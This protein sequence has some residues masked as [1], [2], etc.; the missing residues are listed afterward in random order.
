[1]TEAAYSPE[2]QAM[3]DRAGALTA[4]EA[5]TLGR[6]WKSDEGIVLS[7]PSVG[8]G[9]QGGVDLPVITNE[10]LIGA[11]E[12]ALDA[13]GK[14]GR[15]DEIEAAREAGRVVV[16]D[17]RHSHDDAYAKDGAEEAVRSAVL[18]TGVRDLVTDDDYRLLTAAWAKVVDPA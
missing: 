6:L 11:W 8:M 12:R 5:E 9:I 4:E 15:V 14:A 3:I 16:Q 2:L 10:D 1:M 17:L 13:A 7:S 18:A